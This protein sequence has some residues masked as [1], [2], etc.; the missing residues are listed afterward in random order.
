VLWGVSG[1]LHACTQL[2]LYAAIPSC[3]RFLNPKLCSP[4]SPAT[5]LTFGEE[6][7]NAG[8]EKGEEGD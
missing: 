5:L 4:Q 7:S 2:G 3:L 8:E 1:Y 6:R